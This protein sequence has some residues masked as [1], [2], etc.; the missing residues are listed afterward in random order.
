[1]A[2]LC[3]QTILQSLRSSVRLSNRIGAVDGHCTAFPQSGLPIADQRGV[4][5]LMLA[6]AQAARPKAAVERG[7]EAAM[8]RAAMRPADVA[9]QSGSTRSDFGNS[10]RSHVI[11]TALWARDRTFKVIIKE[12]SSRKPIVGKA[13]RLGASRHSPACRGFFGRR[14]RLDASVRSIRHG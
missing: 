3:T 11:A 14:S 7:R 4:Q 12:P 10:G 2:H 6:T 8:D 5:A 13:R 1:M 9:L